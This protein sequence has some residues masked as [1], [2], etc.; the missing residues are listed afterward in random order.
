MP[1]RFVKNFDRDLAS[2]LRIF[3]AVDLTHT[4]GADGSL[5]CVGT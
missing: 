2:Q 1:Q 5:D 4:P 3:G